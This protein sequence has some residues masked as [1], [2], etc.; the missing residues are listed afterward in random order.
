[1]EKQ[2]KNYFTR[3]NIVLFYTLFT[4]IIHNYDYNI[5]KLTIFYKI[6]YVNNNN[7]NNNRKQFKF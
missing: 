7:H 1:M 4:Y 5:K 2:G 6:A 3:N